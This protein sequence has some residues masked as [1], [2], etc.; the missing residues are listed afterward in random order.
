MH[1]PAG[2][3]F[4]RHSQWPARRGAASISAGMTT[5]GQFCDACGTTNRAEA[6]F[7]RQCGQEFVD[8]S[9]GDPLLRARRLVEQGKHWEALVELER[10]LSRVPDS[11]EVRFSLAATLLKMGEFARG[12][13]ELDTLAGAHPWSPA[14]EAYRAGALMC[15]G[16]VSDA[17]DVLDAAAARAPDDFYVTL[18][19]GEL[20]YRLGIFGVAV[21][22]L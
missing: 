16:H 4:V 7:C 5:A 20:Y 18:K 10:A 15:L 2:I 19:R 3:T 12:L 14:V 22:S 1:M 17:K 9:T 13:R 11:F 6:R 21:R 8:A